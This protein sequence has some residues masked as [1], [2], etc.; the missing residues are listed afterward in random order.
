MV[1]TLVLICIS[2]MTNDWEGNGNPLQ[3]VLAWRIPGMVESGG[4]PSSF[5]MILHLLYFFFCEVS[6]QVFYSFLIELFVS[7]LW[8][9]KNSL[10]IFYISPLLE[11]SLIKKMD[12]V[13]FQMVAYQTYFGY[14]LKLV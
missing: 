4:P 13:V 8:S 2:L 14:F 6:V 9:L 12:D 1:S 11:V 3:W 5:Q 7:L 10:Y